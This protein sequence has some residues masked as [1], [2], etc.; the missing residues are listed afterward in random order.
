MDITKLDT[1]DFVALGITAMLTDKSRPIELSSRRRARSDASVFVGA[2]IEPGSWDVLI[3]LPTAA[4]RDAL[5]ATLDSD[6]DR[7]KRL[8]GVING[9]TVEGYASLRRID[10]P[11]AATSARLTFEPTFPAW[12]AVLPVTTSATRTANG[13]LTATVPGNTRTAPTVRVQPTAQRPA[14][15]GLNGT[16][17]SNMTG[18]TGG[19]FPAN[20]SGTVAQSTVSPRTGAG[21]LRVTVA[22]NT[23]ATV[24][25][26]ITASAPIPVKPGDVVAVSVW[27]KISAANLRG[28]LVI[29]WINAAGAEIGSTS[30]P[31]TATLATYTQES[32]SAVAPANAASFAIRLNAVMFASGAVGTID[33]DDVVASVNGA[34][35]GWKRRTRYRIT[36]TSD[37]TWYRMPARISLGSTTAVVSGG[38]ALAS[39]DDVRVW[40]RGREVARTL[41]TWNSAASYVWIVLPK[42]SPGT[43]IDVD[44]M[45]HN[46]NAGAPPVLAYPDLPPFDLPTSSNGMWRYDDDAGE[47]AWYLSSGVVAPM[48]DQDVPGAWRTLM[49]L[50]NPDNVDDVNQAPYYL[51]GAAYVAKFHATRAPAGTKQLPNEGLGD[52][53]GLHH[54]CGIT[55]VA[56]GLTYRNDYIDATKVADGPIGKVVVLTRAS[57]AAGWGVHYSIST[58]SHNAYT[59]TGR[60]T[61]TPAAPVKNVA[62]GVWPLNEVSIKEETVVGNQVEARWTDYCDVS[63]DASKMVITTVQAETEVYEVAVVLAVDPNDGY[64][65]ANELRLGVAGSTGPLDLP[66]LAVELNQHV[67]LN[68]ETRQAEIWNSALT[69][70]VETIPMTAVR[71]VRVQNVFGVATEFRQSA[72]LP[73]RPTPAGVPVTI[74][75]TPMG[76]LDIDVL[77]NGEFI[78]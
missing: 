76:T 69:A 24:K 57:G 62:F 7:E 56:V 35:V 21:H 4:A 31:G 66:R 28:D 2:S 51:D 44:V 60:V 64:S 46:L 33:F 71:P 55:S 18:W 58:V 27:E 63:W 72:W 29:A 75:E 43:S 3:T 61:H 5:V 54:P 49:T 65:T 68:G 37:E 52:G 47:G 48:I 39:G 34:T 8:E 36:N 15:L 1:L 77:V 45:W 73:L 17:D 53:I 12:R 74:S 30:D 42:L 23:T 10:L 6:L 9:I 19:A 59:A 22:T 78:P 16:F 14:N 70:K 38:R 50:A 41:V 11:T 20:S 26:V 67:V 13:S 40:L 25:T 32:L